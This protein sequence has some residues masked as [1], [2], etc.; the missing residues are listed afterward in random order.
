MVT[1]TGFD[2]NSNKAL[3]SFI[4]MIEHD[5]HENLHENRL[6]LYRHVFCYVCYTK[7]EIIFYK[8]YE[9]YI[10]KEVIMM[11][12]DPHSWYPILKNFSKIYR[13]VLI[14]L[15]LGKITIFEDYFIN[16]WF[17]STIIMLILWKISY[18]LVG[19][20]NLKWPSANSVIYMIIYT[21][22]TCLVCSIC[23]LLYR[24]GLLPIIL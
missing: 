12:Y 23:Q 24:H 21:I 5:L 3:L 18:K 20:L 14:A 15:T 17:Q 7:F 19:K 9:L 4:L 22:L 1:R 8:T 6:C 13:W 2:Q 10:R 11:I 16:D